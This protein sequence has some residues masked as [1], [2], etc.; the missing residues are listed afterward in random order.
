[1]D[2]KTQDVVVAQAAY[3]AAKAVLEAALEAAEKAAQPVYQ[4]YGR[5][6]T[7]QGGV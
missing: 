2:Q 4:E 5:L 7:T 3:D 1:M 6:G